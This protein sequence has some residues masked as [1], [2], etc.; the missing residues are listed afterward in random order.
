MVWVFLM[1]RMGSQ[2]ST[3]AQRRRMAL[4]VV[5]LLLVDIIWVVSSELT[6]V[7]H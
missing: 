5:I 4:G 2:G 3:V 7:R 6:S 1:N